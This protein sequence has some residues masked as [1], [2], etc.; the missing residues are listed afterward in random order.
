MVALLV[1]FGEHWWALLVSREQSQQQH[2]VGHRQT[3][4][5]N[6]QQSS[7]AV[8]STK[9]E[10]KQNQCIT[11]IRAQAESVLLERCCQWSRLI[12]KC[13]TR[14]GCTEKN[15]TIIQCL[16]CCQQLIS[17]S[18]FV[19]IDHWSQWPL[20]T[21]SGQHSHVWQTID[22]IDSALSVAQNIWDIRSQH[23]RSNW[24]DRHRHHRNHRSL[25]TQLLIKFS[26]V[27]YIYR[28]VCAIDCYICCVFATNRLMV[29]S[30]RI[31]I[32]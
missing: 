32:Q 4:Q 17:G 31:C 19:C 16:C 23:N 5:C 10:H 27:K 29:S 15:K 12:G 30:N 22:S 8:L 28:N 26:N 24:S 18:L 14:Y 1:G 21:L 7:T 3:L 9:S 11:D 6:R 25:S 2:S 20:M 13:V